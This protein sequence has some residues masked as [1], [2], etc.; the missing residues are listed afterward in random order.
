MLR[1]LPRLNLA[2]LS[3]AS[4]W[5]EP[6]EDTKSDLHTAVGMYMAMPVKV[7][8]TSSWQL[9]KFQNSASLEMTGGVKR[10]L[11]VRDRYL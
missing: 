6:S 3:V 10:A 5:P 7:T 2:N 9:T 1:D 4:A 8:G 11:D